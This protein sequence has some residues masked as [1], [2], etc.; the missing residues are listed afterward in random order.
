VKLDYRVMPLDNGYVYGSEKLADGLR[1]NAKLPIL[2]WEDCPVPEEIGRFILDIDTGCA[3]EIDHT[4]MLPL[5]VYLYQRTDA[6]GW[7]IFQACSMYSYSIE[8]RPMKGEEGFEVMNEPA[9]DASPADTPS[10]SRWYGESL[11]E[12]RASAERGI[13]EHHPKLLKEM[14]E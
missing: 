8:V 14:T 7:H 3:D 2:E 5:V 9:P 11:R 4:V 13:R 6:H 12:I 10:V 1:W